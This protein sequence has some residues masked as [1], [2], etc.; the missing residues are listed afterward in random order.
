MRS[1]T[2]ASAMFLAATSTLSA[3]APTTAT[4]YAAKGLAAADTF[5]G[6]ASLCN[7]EARIRNVNTPRDGTTGGGQR[8]SGAD[9][10]DHSG[11]GDLV[12]E[13][14]PT[15]VFD[16]LYF[17]GTAEVNT[18]LYGT[19]AG[20]I[21]ID[22]MNNDE[23]AEHYVLG[24][25]AELGLDPAAIAYV[26]VTHGHGDHYG[27]ADYIAETLGIDILMTQADWDLVDYIGTHPRFG[28]PP[29]PG[30]VV[31]DGEVIQFG[32]SE[33]QI[34]VTP[35]HTPGTISPI[36][37][38]FDNGTR[39]AALLWGGT[40]FNFG[41]NVQIFETYA[42]SAAKMR[43]VSFANGVDVFISAHSKRDGSVEKLA[44][45]TG[46][47]PGEAHPFV[48]DERGYDLFDVLENCALAQAARFSE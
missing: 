26:L 22:G 35:G 44:A 9:E 40:G 45:L 31:S 25:M 37:E 17:L 2:F 3:Q 33:I 46:R 14:P 28:P 20:Y 48:W 8:N 10:H 43:E 4:E 13:V 12:F 15:Q 36:L 41:A 27:G 5:P 42:Q 23:E 38:V 39:H 24:G 30:Q 11:E 7:L 6:Y 29:T 32:T 1:A 16:N 34:H 47:Q 18:W 21:L 19:E